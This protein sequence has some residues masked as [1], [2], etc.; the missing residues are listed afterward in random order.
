MHF[1]GIWRVF[2]TTHSNST[3]NSNPIKDMKITLNRILFISAACVV[4]SS[5]SAEIV[6]HYEFNEADATVA[7]SAA[8]T[9]TSVNT[10]ALGDGYGTMNGSGQ[11]VVS[12]DSIRVNTS[13]ASDI[14]SGTI[15]YRIDFDS[16]DTS[17]ANKN[18]KF[19]FR[20]RS[21]DTD[22]SPLNKNLEVTLASGTGATSNI[23]TAASTGSG[24]FNYIKGGFANPNTG[25]VSFII[26]ANTTTDTYSIW[27]DNGLSGTYTQLRENIALN[28]GG[29]TDFVN[30]NALTFDPSG[31]S[32]LID[33]IAL[34]TDF[35]EIVAVS[36]ED[37]TDSVARIA[38][39]ESQLA[40]VTAERDAL[41]TQDAYDTV[42]AERD[43]LPTQDAYDAVVVERDARLTEAQVRDARTGSVLFEVDAENNAMISLVMEETGDLSNWDS[44]TASSHNIAVTVPE[45]Q[46]IR[47]YRFKM[48]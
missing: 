2:Y 15:F 30:V 46:D 29:E 40:A 19:G 47:F 45:G 8:N 33:R 14:F 37:D 3:L 13:M 48:E 36:G 31:G 7:S 21:G 5:A 9:G 38:E 27:W 1:T 42:V 25:G 11:L 18:I 20:L 41:P 34:G 35:N 26:G 22:T 16:W 17:G 6:L 28:L 32:F 44:G 12:T 4:A 39:L 23:S 10:V 24:V 43:A